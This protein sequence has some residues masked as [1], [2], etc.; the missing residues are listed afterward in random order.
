MSGPTKSHEVAARWYGGR[1]N[2]HSPMKVSDQQ[3][4]HL[5]IP[6]PPKRD[7]RLF[8][9]RYTRLPQCVRRKLSKHSMYILKKLKSYQQK[10]LQ[11]M[12][13]HCKTAAHASCTITSDSVTFKGVKKFLYV[14]KV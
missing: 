10:I 6:H 3:L 8:K 7:F 1:A 12:P 11:I 9:D 2:V 13:P 5:K 14:R 4:K